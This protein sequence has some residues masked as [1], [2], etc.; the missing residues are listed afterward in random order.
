MIWIEK[1]STLI[2]GT[3]IFVWY[4]RNSE[5]QKNCKN[6]NNCDNNGDNNDKIN[7]E[8]NESEKDEKNDEMKLGTNEGREKGRKVIKERK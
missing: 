3:K 2:V 8:R 7:R 1:E 5:S 4:Y 6:K